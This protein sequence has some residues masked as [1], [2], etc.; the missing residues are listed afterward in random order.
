[1]F[2]WRRKS[3]IAVVRAFIRATNAR[4]FAAIDDVFADDI[5]LIDVTG[6]ESE[7]R[8]A[9]VD[10]MRKLLAFSPDMQLHA[11]AISSRGDYV[12][13]T[14]SLSGA[15]PAI[16]GPTQ[17]RAR[18]EDEKLVEWQAFS[19]HLAPSITTLLS[20]MPTPEPALEEEPLQSPQGVA[21]A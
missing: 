9:C 1:M 13:I 7:G 8:D 2:R 11:D 12:L 16:G 10:H 4:D 21:N 15:D 19:A 14:G 6:R 20:T 3:S 18:V 17:W 5:H